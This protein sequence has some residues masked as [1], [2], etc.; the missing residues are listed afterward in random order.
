MP[1]LFF[2]R[3]NGICPSLSKFSSYEKVNLVGLAYNARRQ[4][5]DNFKST[6]ISGRYAPFILA[7][8]EGFFGGPLAHHLGLWP[9]DLIV[10]HCM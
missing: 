6:R 10:H 8:A 4:T 9:N 5:K 1:A 2:S 7:P 3:Q